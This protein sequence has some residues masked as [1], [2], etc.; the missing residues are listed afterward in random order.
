MCLILMA[1]LKGAMLPLYFVERW[2]KGQL[3][4]AAAPIGESASV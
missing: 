4:I 3:G 2:A 1:S